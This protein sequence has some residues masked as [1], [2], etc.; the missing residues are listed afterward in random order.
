MGTFI[1]KLIPLDG[2]ISDLIDVTDEEVLR[3][4]PTLNKW[5]LQADKKIKS[6]YPF[7]RKKSVYTVQNC[8][9]PIPC[10]AVFALYLLIGNPGC[11]C[12]Q[13]WSQFD[14]LNGIQNSTYL[15]TLSNGTQIQQTYM[16][17]EGDTYYPINFNWHLQGDSI[18]IDAANLNGQVVTLLYFGYPED[19]DGNILVWDSHADA[20]ANWLQKQ[21]A[22]K[23]QWKNFKRLKLSNIEMSYIQTLDIDYHR[24]V[25]HARADD[26]ETSPTEAD[27][28]YAFIN[29]PISG[30]GNLWL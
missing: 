12:F 27:H 30:K 20:I 10:D 29:N 6:P 18:V 19:A 14:N 4:R 11:D 26:A 25:R 5:A 17:T 13:L 15:E 9:I 23:L 2:I 3:I 16:W 24:S 22:K 7:Q 21:I 1:K 28:I 8:C